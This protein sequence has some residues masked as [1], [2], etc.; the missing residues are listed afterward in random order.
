MQT[1]VNAYY[2]NVVVF[3]VPLNRILQNLIIFLNSF[4]TKGNLTKH[5][6]SKAHYKKCLEKGINPQTTVDDDDNQEEDCSGN[7]VSGRDHL[8]TNDD[9]DTISDEYSDGDADELEIDMDSS[10]KQNRSLHYNIQNRDI[11][12]SLIEYTNSSKLETINQ[13]KSL[14]LQIHS[15]FTV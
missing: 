9:C 1:N 11:V 7:N 15:Q 14:F 5:R 2:F 12:F 3:F 4:K 10:G 13:I 6:E 8:S